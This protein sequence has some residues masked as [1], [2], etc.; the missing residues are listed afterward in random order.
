MFSYGVRRGFV[1]ANT[2]LVLIVVVYSYGSAGAGICRMDAV[3]SV[4]V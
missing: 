3:A 4:G 2:F 1:V